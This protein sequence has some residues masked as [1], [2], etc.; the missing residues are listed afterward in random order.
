MI[1]NK[2]MKKLIIIFLVAIGISYLTSCEEETKD[3]VL[4]ISQTVLPGISNPADGAS[5]ILTK[6]EAGNVMTSF[7]WSQTQYNLT[8][9]EVT[10]YILQM[11]LAGNAFAEPIDLVNTKG[12]SFEITVG[13]MNNT[14][15]GVMELSADEPHSLEFRV[16]SFINQTTEYSDVFSAVISITVTPYEEAVFVKPI[17]LLGSGTTIGWDNTLALP[18]Q[19]IGS[20]KFARV[21]TLTPGTD[22]FIKFISVLGAWAPQWGTDATGTSEAGPLVYRPDEQTADPPAIPFPEGESGDYYIMADTATLVYETFLTSGSLFLVGDATPAGW[23]AGAA[24]AF[25]EGPD[26]VF[27]ITT[28]LNASGAMKFLEVQGAWAPQWGTNDKGN[29]KKGLLV[30]RPTESVPDPPSIPAPSTAGSYKITVDMT[31]MQYTI[32][33]Q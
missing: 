22:Q 29:A 25:T 20:G 21:E 14:L 19:H 7:E 13:T 33:A 5:F 8:N 12:T 16:R 23:D 32:E 15:L 28:N 10:N 4:D 2:K 9:L 11:D 1:K 18:M 3:P 26:H 30:Y 31:T 17:Y 24:I 27:T 6:E